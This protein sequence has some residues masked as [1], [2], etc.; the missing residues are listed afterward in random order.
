MT[1]N[2]W[3]ASAAMLMCLLLA[4]PVAAQHQNEQGQ[5]GHNRH[6][7][8]EHGQNRHNGTTYIPSP[9]PTTLTLIAL[10]GGAAALVRF[11]KSRRNKQFG[12][13]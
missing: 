13:G 1:V 9:E 10:G 5:N 8:N 7:Q 2:L 6:G 4:T 11:R 12:N 3:L